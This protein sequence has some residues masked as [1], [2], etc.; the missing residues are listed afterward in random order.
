MW[1]KSRELRESVAKQL[2]EA[3]ALWKRA[4]RPEFPC[5]EAL[6]N[7]ATGTMRR[8]FSDGSAAKDVATSSLCTMMI[9]SL[10]GQRR[11]GPVPGGA[12]ASGRW[13]IC[14]SDQVSPRHCVLRQRL[15]GRLTDGESC[16][17]RRCEAL[18]GSLPFGQGAEA[19]EG[20]RPLVVARE[21]KANAWPPPQRCI[22]K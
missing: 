14:W 17:M 11:L 18:A 3:V 6:R 4:T 16:P 10:G 7:V 21:A 12:D 20:P 15:K 9:G 13:D 2:G 5:P 1:A 8:A 19:T 22:M